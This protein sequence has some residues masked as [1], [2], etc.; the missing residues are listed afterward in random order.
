MRK[1][2]HGHAIPRPGTVMIHP[3]YTSCTVT[4]MMRPSRLG[5]RAFVAPSLAF[6]L[7]NT[8]FKDITARIGGNGAVVRYPKDKE[9][10]VENDGFATCRRTGFEGG[11]VIE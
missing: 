2:G 3:R 8:V 4:T 1:R 7:N 6:S 11:R 5:G 9:E 10:T